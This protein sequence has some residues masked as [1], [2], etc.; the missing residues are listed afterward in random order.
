MQLFFI[1][2]CLPVELLNRLES[3]QPTR[4][5]IIVIMFSGNVLTWRLL[6]PLPSKIF[7]IIKILQFLEISVEHH[8]KDKLGLF[9]IMLDRQSFACW[10]YT[11]LISLCFASQNNNLI[12]C[13]VCAFLYITGTYFCLWFLNTEHACVK[14]G[15]RLT[16]N[17]FAQLALLKK[18][19]FLYSP[20]LPRNC[21]SQQQRKLGNFL[22]LC[23]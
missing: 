23:S 5:L 13:L 18:L 17:S 16:R 12:D 1:L 21:I 20:E 8:L 4:T 7:G 10:V 2:Y 14:G 15:L 6:L 11:I 9:A 22:V 3:F 19:P